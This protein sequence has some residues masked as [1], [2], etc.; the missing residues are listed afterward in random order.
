MLHGACA[1]VS[2]DAIANGFQVELFVAVVA[3]LTAGHAIF[4]AKGPVLDSSDACCMGLDPWSPRP[5][6]PPDAL[7]RRLSAPEEEV[8]RLTL[9]LLRGGGGNPAN[10][11]PSTHT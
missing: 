8:E 4:N 1:D 9:P 10:G 3:G 2:G 6:D 11:Q 7:Q 5:D